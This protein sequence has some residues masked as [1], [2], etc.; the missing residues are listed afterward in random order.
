MSTMAIPFPEPLADKYKP[1]AIDDFVGL[2]KPRK[3]MQRFIANPF[4]SVWLFEGPSGTGKTTMAQAICKAVAGELH[5]I[6]SQSCDLATVKKTVDVC[7]RYPYDWQNGAACKF[8]FV[9]CEEADQMSYPAQLA[10]LSILDGS[11]MPPNTIFVFTCNAVDRFEA[12]FLS[13]CRRLEFSSYGMAAGIKSLLERI[14][15]KETDNPTEAP[16]FARIAKDSKNNVRDALMT[17]EVAIMGA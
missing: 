5:L 13:R 1:T 10:F 14:W 4:P 11:A 2:E 6:T 12:R 3:I 15:A 16:D 17:L 8:H 7:H 9:L